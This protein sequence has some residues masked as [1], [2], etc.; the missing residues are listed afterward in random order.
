MYQHD[1]SAQY[2]YNRVTDKGRGMYGWD[3]ICI[4]HHHTQLTLTGYT[5]QYST[6][7]ILPS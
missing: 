4:T 2:Y 5:N 1:P 6:C 7:N 3:M